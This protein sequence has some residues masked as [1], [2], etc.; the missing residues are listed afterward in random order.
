MANKYGIHPALVVSCF[1]M[2]G[3]NMSTAIALEKF[4]FFPALD[5]AKLEAGDLLPR[6]SRS[7]LP[8]ME[9]K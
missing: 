8:G 5:P 4:A 9:V 2:L 7:L 1:A 6:R 3:I